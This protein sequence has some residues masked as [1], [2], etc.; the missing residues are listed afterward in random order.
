MQHLCRLFAAGLV[1][2]RVATSGFN[3]LEHTTALFAHNAASRWTSDTLLRACKRGLVY[4]V[5]AQ[6]SALGDLEQQRQPLLYCRLDTAFWPRT[7]ASSALEQY[8]FAAL[9]GMVRS[10]YNYDAG[11][12][13][14]LTTPAARRLRT[15]GTRHDEGQRSRADA[16]PPCLP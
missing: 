3:L 2:A 7:L 12:A 10:T 1:D 6:V 14:A 15:R 8:R 13:L 11:S 5:C 16:P 4:S 9:P